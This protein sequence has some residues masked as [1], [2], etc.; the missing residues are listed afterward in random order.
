MIDYSYKILGKVY[1]EDFYRNPLPFLCNFKAKCETPVCKIY[2]I[3]VKNN[4]TKN[5]LEVIKENLENIPPLFSSYLL[6]KFRGKLTKDKS[7]PLQFIGQLEDKDYFSMYVWYLHA[8]SIAKKDC[9]NLEAY[10]FL[11]DFMKAKDYVTSSH[12]ILN[13]NL[14]PFL[15]DIWLDKNKPISPLYSR[16]YLEVFLMMPFDEQ[17]VQSYFTSE[18]VFWRYYYDK[19]KVAVER[20][21]RR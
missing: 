18:M 9:D 17:K 11:K 8:F 6:C 13:N 12:M 14:V 1:G 20:F 16:H 10:K 21:S 7:Y 2:N 3:L 15:I 4:V 19:I 5:D